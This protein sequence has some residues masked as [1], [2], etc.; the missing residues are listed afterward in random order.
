MTEKLVHPALTQIE[1]ERDDVYAFEIDGHVSQEEMDG[2]YKILENAYE[3]HGKINLLVRLGRY[4][5]FDWSALFSE[6]TYVGKYQAIRHMRRYALVGGPTWAANAIG[7][8]G[9]LFR[10]DVRHFELDDET[11]AWKWIYGNG[12]D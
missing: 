9:P 12:E 8:F 4:D 7:F 10:M 11:E 5:G 2:A 3:K 1:T 6:K